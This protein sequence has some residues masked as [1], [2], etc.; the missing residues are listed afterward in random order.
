MV[1]MNTD[2]GI[3]HCVMLKLCNDDIDDDGAD[4]DNYK[5]DNT[6]DNTCTCSNDNNQ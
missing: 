2:D 4:S 1:V 6:G 3:K 5:M